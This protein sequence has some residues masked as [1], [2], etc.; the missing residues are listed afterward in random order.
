MAAKI[1][2]IRTAYPVLDPPKIVIQIDGKR[3][4]FNL[5]QAAQMAADLTVAV[6]RLKYHTRPRRKR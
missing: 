5:E 1:P 3:Y 4:D 2:P 6:T